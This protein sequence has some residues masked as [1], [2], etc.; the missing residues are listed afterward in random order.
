MADRFDFQLDRLWDDLASGRPVD[1][2][3]DDAK[4]LG[5]LHSLH[6]AN[7]PGSARERA[8][9]RIFDLEPISGEDVMPVSAAALPLSPTNGRSSPATREPHSDL[10]TCCH[11][12]P[13]AL[14]LHCR[15]PAHSVD[16]FERLV[17]LRA[18]G[19]NTPESPGS[20]P[21]HSGIPH[22]RL[23]DV[24]R[25]SG[26]HWIDHGSW[27]HRA[28]ANRLDLPRRT[29]PPIAPPPSLL[30]LPISAVRT[31]ISMH[32]MPRPA[33]NNGASRAIR[34]WNRRRRWPDGTVY[35]TSDNG[36]FYAIDA[37][38]GELRWHVRA[39]DHPEL[40]CDRASIRLCVVGMTTRRSSAS[41]PPPASNAGQS[42]SVAPSCARPARTAAR[43]MPRVAM[44][45][46]TP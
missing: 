3:Q 42:P 16:R 19:D 41:I 31:G 38:T 11:Q 9:H 29:A 46:S 25:Q 7:P 15:R 12:H 18:V 39:G 34:R 26:P 14:D 23:A 5:A 27:H 44:A 10:A 17:H 22:R 33:K 1:A 28:T 13:L 32:S 36:T 8:R 37:Q 2:T 30:G 6:A 20:H 43:S 24:S 4:L 35:I 21:C 45:R 40:L